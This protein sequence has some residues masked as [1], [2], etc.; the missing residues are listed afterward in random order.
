MPYTVQKLGPDLCMCHLLQYSRTVSCQ[1]AY[2]F[3]I[4]SDRA[5]K[6]HQPTG[7]Y[8]GR[9]LF[10]EEHIFMYYLDKLQN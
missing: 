4:H 10:R 1:T 6:H 7:S 3:T 5:P 9:V 2:L 8:N